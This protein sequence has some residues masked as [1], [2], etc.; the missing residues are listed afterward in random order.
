MLLFNWLVNLK[1]R[2]VELIAKNRPIYGYKQ[3]SSQ[4]GL[5]T[6]KAPKGHFTYMS[7]LSG[8]RC[9]VSMY[10]CEVALR[11][12]LKAKSKVAFCKLAKCRLG[13][14]HI[15]VALSRPPSMS[16]FAS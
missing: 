6:Q 8:L 3:T 7:P 13:K 4:Y 1:Q 2:A 9:R 16:P 11:W 10:A 5:A 12:P 14:G 15:E